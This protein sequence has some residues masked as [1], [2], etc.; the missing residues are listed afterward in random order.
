MATLYNLEQIMSVVRSLDLT[1]PISEGFVA[2]SN[3]EALV[4]PV[5]EII[6]NNPPGETHIKYGHIRG[7]DNYVV[8]IASGFYENY[9][10]GLPSSSGLMLVFSRKTGFVESILHDEGYLT[11]VRTA[12][13]GRICADYLAPSNITG[14]GVLGTG[15]QARM[16]VDY[17][18]SLFQCKNI[19]VWGRSPENAGLYEVDMKAKG[20]DVR[21]MPTPGSVAEKCNLIITTT[22]AKKPLLFIKD[23][24]QGTHITAI[25]SDTPEKQELDSNIFEDADIIVADSI[26]QCQKRGEIS[27]AL[28]TGVLQKESI[29]ELGRIIENPGLLNRGDKDI[30]VADLTGVAVQD[31]QIAAAVCNAF[32]ARQK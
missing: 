18:S 4:P 3:G 7:M 17:L 31:I 2:Y 27:R 5:G 8:K 25:G 24:R 20:F 19:F 26:S 15:I 22:P 28:K 6:F 29:L 14:I 9:K 11:N 16:Q 1:D 10:S 32:R 21:I 23:I 12:V 30:S 13:A